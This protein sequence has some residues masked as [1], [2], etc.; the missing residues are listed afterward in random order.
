MQFFGKQMTK[1]NAKEQTGDKPKQEGAGI[2]GLVK[3]FD[4]REKLKLIDG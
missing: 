4:S 3:K 2:K 1:G